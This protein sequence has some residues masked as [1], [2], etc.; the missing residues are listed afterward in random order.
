[1]AWAP[2]NCKLAVCTADRVVL[3]YDEQG[4]KRD[5]FSTKPVASKV[6]ATTG[7]FPVIFQKHIWIIKYIL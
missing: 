6:T 1:M 5:K 4:E 7:L 2:N 3:L